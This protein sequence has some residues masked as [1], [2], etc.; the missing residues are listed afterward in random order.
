MLLLLLYV[1]IGTYCHLKKALTKF[2]THIPIAAIKI[3][4]HTTCV[5]HTVH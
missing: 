2:A 5:V 4:Y 1:L 3:G